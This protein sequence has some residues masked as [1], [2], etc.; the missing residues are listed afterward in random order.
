[1]YHPV[2]QIVSWRHI[3]VVAICVV[4]VVVVMVLGVGS[5]VVHVPHIPALKCHMYI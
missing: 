2:V 5:V 3:L 4:N 1:M